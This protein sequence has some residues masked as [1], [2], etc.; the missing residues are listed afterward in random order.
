M[1]FFVGQG[2]GRGADCAR[3]GFGDRARGRGRTASI[4]MYYNIRISK[5]LNIIRYRYSN[6][7]IF[8]GISCAYGFVRAGGLEVDVFAFAER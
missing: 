3:F 7:E 1:N 4:L 2:V 6:M 5:Y 8:R